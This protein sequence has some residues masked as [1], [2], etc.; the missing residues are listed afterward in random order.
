MS[1][2]KTPLLNKR[3]VLYPIENNSIW[4]FYKKAVSCFWTVEE[5]D[6]SKD[7]DDWNKLTSGE[8][9]FIKNTLAFFAASD[10]IV[11]ENLALRFINEVEQIEA[12]FFYS[13]QTSIENIHSECYSLLIDTYIDNQ[14]EKTEL[15]NAIET[16]PVIA[17]KAQ[18]CFKWIEDEKTEFIY[19]LVAFACVEGIFFSSS[20][21]SIY[22]LKKRGLMPGLT[23]SNELISRDESLHTEFAIH[24][25]HLLKTQGVNESLILEMVKEAVEL[26]K[27]FSRDSLK[28]NLIGMNSDLMS[29]YIEFVGDRLLVQLGLNKYWNTPNPFDFM[30]LISMTNKA[31]F[32]ESKVSQYSMAAVSNA[33]QG[34]TNG[35]FEIVDDF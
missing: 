21:C 15:F 22:W 18:W 29:Q 12:K 30:E 2:R 27:E 19:R 24:L 5:V 26:E 34:S 6:L 23:F 35:G 14:E 10:G 11:N 4:D 25:F 13:F 31:N 20:F 33:I 8:K 7:K 9:I 16:I 1:D 17:K 32:F 3:Y 28:A